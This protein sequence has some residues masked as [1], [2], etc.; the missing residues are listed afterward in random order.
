MTETY[1]NSFASNY[2]RPSYPI[3]FGR[4]HDEVTQ[5]LSPCATALASMLR[6]AAP[7]ATQP[8]FADGFVWL[9]KVLANRTTRRLDKHDGS[10]PAAASEATVQRRKERLLREVSEE[11]EAQARP[12]RSH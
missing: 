6:T 2:L 7:R 11:L 5:T 8:T 4:S 1:F 9:M 3:D 12:V 10:V